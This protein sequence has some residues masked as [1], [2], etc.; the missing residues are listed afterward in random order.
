MNTETILNR[1]EAKDEAAHLT[2]QTGREIIHRLTDCDCDYNSNCGR[3]AGEGGY[4]LLVYAKC[5][6]PVQIEDGDPGCMDS[7][8]AK[9]DVFP[10][11]APALKS[12]LENQSEIDEQE[13]A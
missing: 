2:R 9:R 10:V 7:R 6:H 12:L 8:C 4:F 11:Q 5:Y 13:A 3:C 1:A